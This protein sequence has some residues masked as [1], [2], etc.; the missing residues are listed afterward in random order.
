MLRMKKRREFVF[1]NVLPFHMIWTIFII[2]PSLAFY[3]ALYYFLLHGD[4]NLSFII[5]FA[6]LYFGTCYVL[7]KALSVEVAIGFDEHY[8][9]LRK[10]K[11]LQKYAKADITGFYAHDY[12]TETPELKSSKIYFT[13]SL[14]NKKSI[15]LY[16]VEYKNQFEEEKGAKLKEFLKEVQSELKFSKR[17]RKNN[18]Q[19]IYWY[20][21]DQL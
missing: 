9:Y 6:L 7:L 21:G 15:H 5:L 17:E 20:S 1:K 11:K 8:L 19:N 10:G 16:D 12:E 13:F 4:F 18:Y 14:K 3:G 2:I